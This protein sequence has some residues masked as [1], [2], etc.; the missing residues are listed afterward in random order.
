MLRLGILHNQ[1]LLDAN[2]RRTAF[3]DVSRNPFKLLKRAMCKYVGGEAVPECMFVC[4]CVRV[5]TFA[6]EWRSVCV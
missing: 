3:S 4:V 1:A 5:C 2:P 6:C